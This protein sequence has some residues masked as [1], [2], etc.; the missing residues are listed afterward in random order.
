MPFDLLALGCSLKNS[1]HARLSENSEASRTSTADR[2]DGR[3]G[4]SWYALQTRSRHEKRVHERL[5]WHGL[6]DFLPL[7]ETVSCWKN[8]CKMTVERPLFPSYLF[9]QIDLRDR[10][11]VLGL[12]GVVSLVGAGFKPCPLP[13]GEVERLRDGL[14]LREVQ[15]HSYLTEGQRVRIKSGPLVGL[16][17][18]LQRRNGG[19]RVVLSVD[20]LM[21]CMSVEVGADEIQAAE[22]LPKT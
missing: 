10:A 12:P 2:D 5:L 7:Y 4:V 1:L 19:I 8:G 14:R 6:D 9:V 3:Q 20:V 17:G 18:I 15:P 11:K 16:S 22:I 13:S 21:Q